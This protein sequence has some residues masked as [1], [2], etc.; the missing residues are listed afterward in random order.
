ME[1][2]IKDIKSLLKSYSKKTVALKVNVSVVTLNEVIRGVPELQGVKQPI[3]NNTFE[4]THQGQVLLGCDVVDARMI[5]VSR[6]V[7]LLANNDKGDVAASLELSTVS[8][9]KLLNAFPEHFQNIPRALK[10]PFTLV[11]DLG[12]PVTITRKV[13]AITVEEI[14]EVAA[15]TIVED[16]A[17]NDEFSLKS[18]FFSEQI[19]ENSDEQPVAAAS[20][21]E[22][23]N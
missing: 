1:Y 6:L 22:V 21:Q 14:E 13:A 17:N 4:L 20:E 23:E 18:S 11:N 12:E 19:V 8:L 7:T 9:N 2:T 5:E 16:V 15:P 3:T 10:L